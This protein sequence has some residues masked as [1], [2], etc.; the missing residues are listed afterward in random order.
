M[1]PSAVPQVNP[2]YVGMSTR[3]QVVVKFSATWCGPC[4]NAAP[5]YAE[6]SLKHSDLVFFSIDVDELPV[7]TSIFKIPHIDFCLYLFCYLKI[8]FVLLLLSI[9]QKKSLKLNTTLKWFSRNWS[10]NS[11]YAQLQ[12]SSS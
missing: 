12:R 4:R 11:M 1:I 7:R 5:L 10:R 3:V 9:E 8:Y 2:V 6:L